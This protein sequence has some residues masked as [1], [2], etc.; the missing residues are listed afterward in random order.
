MAQRAKALDLDKRAKLSVKK[1]IQ[2]V[3]LDLS[4]PSCGK[5]LGKWSI[6]SLGSGKSITC[7]NKDCKGV[8]SVETADIKTLLSTIDRM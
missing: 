3:K 1:A 5:T 4:C 7:K 6:A 2:S 8:T